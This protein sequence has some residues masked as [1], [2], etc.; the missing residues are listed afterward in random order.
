MSRV[1]LVLALSDADLAEARLGDDV[2]LRAAVAAVGVCAI[3]GL[4]AVDLVAP[5][6]ATLDVL[7][8]CAGSLLA[9]WTLGRPGLRRLRLLAWL[10]IGLGTVALALATTSAD[11]PRRLLGSLVAGF[12][13]ATA[14]EQDGTRRSTLVNLAL[15]LAVLALAA[16][17][18]PGAGLAAPMTA[19]W[20]AALVAL[21]RIQPRR[22]ALASY[23]AMRAQPLAG[24]GR[25]LF[26]SALVPIAATLVVGLA[27][28]AVLHALRGEADQRARSA[29]TGSDYGF[30][31]AAD[32]DPSTDSAPRLS[33]ASTGGTIDLRERGD[34]SDAE[35]MR[36]PQDSPQLWRTGMLDVYTGIGWQQAQTGRVT[37]LVTGGSYRPHRPGLDRFRLSGSGPDV[38]RP[39]AGR[40]PAPCRRAPPY[41]PGA[42]QRV[43][44]VRRRRARHRD[45]RAGAAGH[46]GAARPGRPPGPRRLAAGAERRRRGGRRRPARPGHD[47]IRGHLARPSR[48]GRAGRGAAPSLVGA[49]GPDA[50][51]PA[52]DR[53]T[54]LP[55]GVPSR[56]RQLG[57]GLVAATPNRVAAVRAVETYLRSTAVYTLDSPV[58]VDGTDA[59]DDFLFVA[60][61]GFCEQFASAEVVLLR[62][63]GIPARLVVGFSGGEPSGDADGTRV[64]RG[65]DA[66]AWVEVWIPGRGWAASD[67]TAGSRLAT[68]G[69][70]ST[71]RAWLARW[72]WAVVLGAS[73]S[74][75]RPVPSCG[76][77]AAAAGGRPQ[78]CSS[79]D[80]CPDP[81]RPGCSRPS[82]GSRSPC[83]TSTSRADRRSRSPTSAT[84]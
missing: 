66:H 80:G 15:G 43:R 22:E 45:R 71:V 27:A 42:Q 56:V 54:T 33:Q 60:G 84:G 35:V 6:L 16:G 13:A 81:A 7:C 5:A 46:L 30:G 41:R 68:E 19:A 58:P 57:L 14:A 50:T 44:H 31:S 23:V 61:A 69:P 24:G 12:I 76:S 21:L 9:R 55:D 49:A 74:S 63:A 62:A 79:S 25:R 73:A 4:A 52:Q 77:R 17:V 39:A 64:V 20:V 1:R 34:L 28:F 8:V 32:G 36:V 59:V 48:D 37:A 70:V 67:P 26:G 40:R 47:D 75:S 72:W 82:R 53:W 10:G 3:V 51:D 18:A 78:P 29:L 38:R 65:T 2:A 11:D 83:G